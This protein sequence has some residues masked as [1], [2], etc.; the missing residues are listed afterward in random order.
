[1]YLIDFDKTEKDIQ[2]DLMKLLIKYHSGIIHDDESNRKYIENE[3]LNKDTVVKIS[4]TIR[5]KN[6]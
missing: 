1:M 4:L 6:I 2:K 5:K 3:S